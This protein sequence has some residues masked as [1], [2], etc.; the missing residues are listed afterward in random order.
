MKIRK[1][2]V[3]NSSSSSFICDI[4]GGSEG[5]YDVCLSDVDMICCESG[6]IFH[7]SCLK[8]YDGS[9][10]TNEYGDLSDEICPICNLKK[11]DASDIIAFGKKQYGWDND[12]AIKDIRDKFKSFSELRLWLKS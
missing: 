1:G 3:S 7:T 12:T 6:H 9:D 10:K 2:F 8:S 5:G 4:C 11:L